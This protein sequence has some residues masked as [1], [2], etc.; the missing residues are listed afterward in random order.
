MWSQIT[1]SLAEL[2]L[3]FTF[4]GN[5]MCLNVFKMMHKTSTGRRRQQCVKYCDW[6]EPTSVL[7]RIWTPSRLFCLSGL[8][9]FMCSCRRSSQVCD[10]GLHGGRLAG[11]IWLIAPPW[12]WATLINGRPE[13]FVR[14]LC[15]VVCCVCVRPPLQNQ[16]VR[17]RGNGRNFD[18]RCRC[19]R[20]SV[21]IRHRRTFC[22]TSSRRHTYA[23]RSVFM[24]VITIMCDKICCQIQFIYKFLVS[25]IRISMGLPWSSAAEQPEGYSES[26]RIKY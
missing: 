1:S 15:V 18:L 13:L 7:N 6:F 21:Y 9:P 10:D 24:S 12:Q 5:Q 2:Y 23:K 22:C 17:T 14:V 3:K 16:H 25:H 11:S 4:R 26:Y 20:A 19:R 8:K